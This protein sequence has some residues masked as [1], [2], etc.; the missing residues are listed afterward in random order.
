MNRLLDAL[1]GSFNVLADSLQGVAA[2][3]GQRTDD[4]SDQAEENPR[5]GIHDDVFCLIRGACVK[6]SSPPGGSDLLLGFPDAYS[7]P[8]LIL[9]NSCPA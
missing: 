9:L 6:L 4:G 1:A 2:R 7:A 3:G 8:T 5:F